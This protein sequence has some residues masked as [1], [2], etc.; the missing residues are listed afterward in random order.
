[1]ISDGRRETEIEF[2]IIICLRHALKGLDASNAYVKHAC[3]YMGRLVNIHL[4]ITL[5]SELKKGELWQRYSAALHGLCP[6]QAPVSLYA[7]R[8]WA[9]C[10]HIGSEL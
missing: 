10:P 4:A 9:Q 7:Q 2:T 3:M 8:R 1:M 5:H 6:S